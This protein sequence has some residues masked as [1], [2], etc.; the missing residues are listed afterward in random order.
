MSRSR[1]SGGDAWAV[2]SPAVGTGLQG[3]PCGDPLRPADP[4]SAADA[5]AVALSGGGF[6]ATLSALGF[7]R[8]LADTGLLPKLRY[9]S[10]VSGGSITNAFLATAWRSLRDRNFTSQAVDELVVEPV[11]EQVSTRSLK[12]ELVRGLWRTLGPMTRTELLALRLDEWFFHGTGLAELDPEVRWIFSAANLT[13]GVR[14]T[15]ERDVF[16]DYAIG[17][18]RT[19]GA[20]LKLSLAVAASAAVPGAFPPVVLQRAH[21]PCA[22]DDPALLDG[23]TYD[24]TGLEAIDGERYRNAFLLVLNAGG[25]LRPGM[26]GHVPVIRDLARANSLLYRQSTAL[27]T[28]AMV[29]RFRR[30]GSAEP[31]GGEVPQGARK[32]ILVDLATDFP[33]GSPGMVDLW[34]EAFPERRTYQGRDLALVPTVFDRLDARLCRALVYR[35]WWLAGAALYAYHP[36]LLPDVASLTPPPL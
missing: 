10:S 18:A 22:T 29:E 31:G 19:E 1:H 7:A 11:V 24:N 9:S 34:R 20:G 6:R 25:L 5:V 2:D 15:F 14:F 4:T 32:G 33:A 12:G 27:R 8:L 17:L 21:F 16:G 13:T 30:G 28:R 26:Y 23:G 3:R 36:K 35:G